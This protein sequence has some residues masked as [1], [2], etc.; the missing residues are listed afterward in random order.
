MDTDK[1]SFMLGAYVRSCKPVPIERDYRGVSLYLR[2]HSENSIFVLA[3][4]PS[5]LSVFEAVND[6]AMRADGYIEQGSC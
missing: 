4:G 3:V 6:I 1:Q 5:I 2:R